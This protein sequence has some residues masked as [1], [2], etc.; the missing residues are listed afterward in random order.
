MRV[1]QV[2]EVE[3]VVSSVIYHPSRQSQFY[4]KFQ[5]LDKQQRNALINYY[6]YVIDGNERPDSVRRQQH[7]NA[8][9]YFPLR[10]DAYT[11]FLSR[12]MS[13]RIYPPF[14]QGYNRAMAIPVNFCKVM[15]TPVLQSL[16]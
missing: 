16:Q 4:S 14:I 7:R 2:N 3:H 8:L 1:L 9:A 15:F 6:Q 12:S 13:M 10:R 5:L 11:S